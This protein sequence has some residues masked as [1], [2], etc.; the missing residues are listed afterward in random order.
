MINL[1]NALDQLDEAEELLA[2]HDPKSREARAADKIR[3]AK[4][5]IRASRSKILDACVPEDVL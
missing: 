4:V 5:K 1:E 3:K 2:E